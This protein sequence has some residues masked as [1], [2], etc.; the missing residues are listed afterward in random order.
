MGIAIENRNHSLVEV[1]LRN[2]FPADDRTVLK[3]VK[4]RRGEIL[5]L[6]LKCGADFSKIPF[7][8]VVEAGDPDIVNLFFNNGADLYKD[9]PFYRGLIFETK[10][11]LSF[12][13]RYL[14]SHPDIKLQAEM[15]L[16]YLVLNKRVKGV[17]LLMWAGIDPR[18]RAPDE[19]SEA[20]DP[21]GWGTAMHD[22]ARMGSLEIIKL[23]KPDS[24]K[25]N[26]N[27]LIC[28]SAWRYDMDLMDYWLGLGAD[29][30]YS[31]DGKHPVHEAV[32]RTVELRCRISKMSSDLSYW[33][34]FSFLKKWFASGA[35]WPNPNKEEVVRLRALFN[36]LSSSMFMDF[37]ELLL[38][39][40]VIP[41]EVLR[42]IT[43]TP[44]IRKKAPKLYTT[45]KSYLKAKAKR[46]FGR[47]YIL[48]KNR[49]EWC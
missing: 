45:M 43:N 24:K 5:E 49:P 2:G 36:E 7:K 27:D 10:I 3:A 29:R 23:L 12:Y 48:K 19:P 32:V 9:F 15:A 35:K 40:E 34:A 22:A 38:D 46:N 31:I 20:S 30:N 18:V 37:I 33:S 14:P 25:D 42:E 11:W 47:P 26:A 6:L 44:N 1:L 21:E 16:R 41:L 17:A 13:K 8:E 4:H 39:N 28:W